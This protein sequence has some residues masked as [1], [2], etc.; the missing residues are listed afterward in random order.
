MDPRY[1]AMAS[2]I[3][4]IIAIW[5][6]FAARTVA[7]GWSLPRCW[8]CGASK[9]RRSRSDGFID[10]AASLLLLRPFRCKGCRVRFYGLRFWEPSPAR[11]RVR[12][13]P[14]RVP[15]HAPAGR[16]QTQNPA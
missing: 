16:L 15:A 8:R 9:V 7:R 1:L 12:L 13:S 4:V 11:L 5:V 3:M 14:A 6:G 10:A 2:V